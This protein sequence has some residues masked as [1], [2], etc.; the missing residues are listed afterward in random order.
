MQE[1]ICHVL[2]VDICID[3]MRVIM[4]IYCVG[5]YHILR[6]SCHILM[7]GEGKMKK[8]GEGGRVRMRKKREKAEWLCFILISWWNIRNYFTWRL[9]TQAVVIV[10]GILADLFSQKKK[11]TYIKNNCSFFF[12]W[13][14]KS[15]LSRKN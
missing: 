10:I 4:D 2:K 11:I 15:K 6:Q 12:F 3:G 1:I 8:Q 14:T 5:S 13:N 9:G 7:E